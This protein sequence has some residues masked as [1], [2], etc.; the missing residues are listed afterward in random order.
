MSDTMDEMRRHLNDMNL[1]L[2]RKVL[3]RTFLFLLIPVWVCSAPLGDGP[4]EPITGFDYLL[5]LTQSATPSLDSHRITGILDYVSEKDL[6]GEPLCQGGLENTPMAY[7]AIDV[8]T[9][10]DHLIRYCFN[11]DIPSCAVAPS[12]IRLSCWRT[13]N[14]A[15]ALPRLWTRLDDV[16]DPIVTHSTYY[17]Q[18]TP[19]PNSGAYYGY[20]SRRT[21][22]LMKYKGQ[23]ALISI[24][25]QTDVSEVGKKGYV[26]SEGDDPDFFYS[27]EQGLN[28]L[29][30]G[31]VK[32]YIYDSYSVAVYL[33]R[34]NGEKGIRYG[35][36]KWLSAGWAGK[37]M[38]KESHVHDGLT[39][40]ARTFKQ[41]ME[42][43]HLPSPDVLARICKAYDCAPSDELKKKLEDYFLAVKGRCSCT[44]DCPKILKKGFDPDRYV[45]NMSPMEMKATLIVDNIR[46]ILAKDGQPGDVAYRPG[47][48]DAKVF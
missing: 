3:V 7:N 4:G 2:R 43:K 29:G 38:V 13:V 23:N 19:D 5:D 20:T 21:L 14:G 26:L 31:W 41:F 12:L 35:V 25:K 28:K 46:H 34:P 9:D 39:R 32:S 1:I 47:A 22:I 24:L 37:N 8:N 16:T 10:M 44:N 15:S 33:E 6:D 17:M 18:N 45:D 30:L 48:D 42:A 11:P 36:F 27:D 40:Y